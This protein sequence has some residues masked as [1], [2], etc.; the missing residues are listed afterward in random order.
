MGCGIGIAVVA[1][2]YHRKSRRGHGMNL[3]LLTVRKRREKKPAEK[4]VMKA[5]MDGN[6]GKCHSLNCT[7]SCGHPVGW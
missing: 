6:H 3:D 1:Y 2:T 5:C 7:C 4:K